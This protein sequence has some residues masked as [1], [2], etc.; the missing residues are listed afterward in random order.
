[1]KEVPE[2]REQ[3]E[4]CAGDCADENH[5]SNYFASQKKEKWQ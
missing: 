5:I 2:K 1:M 3:S 4:D